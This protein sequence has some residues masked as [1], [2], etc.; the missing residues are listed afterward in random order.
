M[1]E[2]ILYGV[3]VVRPEQM[4]T[5]IPEPPETRRERFVRIAKGVAWAVL[6]AVGFLL[7]VAAWALFTFLI[8]APELSALGGFAIGA[9]TFLVWSGRRG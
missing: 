7:G 2:H 9:L 8:Q 3:S 1:A 4:V 6:C 5:I